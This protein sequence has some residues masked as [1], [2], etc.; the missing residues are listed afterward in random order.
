M[1]AITEDLYWIVTNFRNN[2]FLLFKDMETGVWKLT[3]LIKDRY[4]FDHAT[5]LIRIRNTFSSCEVERVLKE[6]AGKKFNVFV[7]DGFDPINHEDIWKTV[8]F[9]PEFKTAPVEVTLKYFEPY[10]WE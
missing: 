10:M 5:D 4:A 7:H 1:N 6:V 3:R 2:R 8:R 9:V